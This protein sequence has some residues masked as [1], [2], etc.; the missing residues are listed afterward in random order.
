M[1]SVLGGKWSFSAKSAAKRWCSV[2]PSL[3]GTQL[4]PSSSANAGS[5]IASIQAPNIRR[6]LRNQI[7]GS[8]GSTK[9]STITGP[10]VPGSLGDG[11][12][13]TEVFA[14]PQRG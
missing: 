5:W 1:W 10:L 4:I 8:R 3:S 14:P 7:R 11:A 12:A 6:H 9:R 2:V 13:R